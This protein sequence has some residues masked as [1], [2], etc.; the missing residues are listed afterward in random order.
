MTVERAHT[1]PARPRL[2]AGGGGSCMLGLCAVFAPCS[3]H[4]FARWSR[5]VKHSSMA[6]NRN[7]SPRKTRTVHRFI[8]RT[9]G[10]RSV[11]R[12]DNAI[13]VWFPI[14]L[15]YATPGF[16]KLGS[17]LTCFASLRSNFMQLRGFGR[18]GRARRGLADGHLRFGRRTWRSTLQ[19]CFWRLMLLAARARA[20]REA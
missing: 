8:P 6:C 12:C 1:P 2:V 10:I 11:H 19:S 3:R 17:V 5:V 16:G 7:E 15:S 18:G 20:R 13:E 4:V 9:P 14:V